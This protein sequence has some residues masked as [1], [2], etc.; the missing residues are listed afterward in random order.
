[1]KYVELKKYISLYIKSILYVWKSQKTSVSLMFIAIPLQ[2]LMPSLTIYLTNL[3]IENLTKGV[4]ERIYSI[5]CVWGLSFLLSNISSPF[6]TAIQGKLTDYLTYKLNYDIMKKSK[7]IQTIDYFEDTIFY[8][9]IQ[10]L[11]SESS[12]RPVNLLIFGTSVISNCILFISM[13]VLFY[14][15]HPVIALLMILAI[16]PQGIIA[17]KLQQ[18]S[19]ETLVSNSEDSRRLSYYSQ[20]L[21]SSETIKD[22]RLFNLYDFFLKKYTTVFE[23]IQ[24]KNQKNRIKKLI[25]SA[26]FL[27]I[28]T[29]ISVSSFIYVIFEIKNGKLGIGSI[30]VFSTSMIYSS[31]AVIRLVTDSSMLYDT[32][33]YMEKFFDFININSPTSDE[34]SIEEFPN[35]I[36][37]IEFKNVNFSY[38]NNTTFALKNISFKVKKG[39]K[40]AIV[41]ENGAGKTTLIK[42]FCHFYDLKSGDI[43]IN[44]NSINLYNPDI[45]RQN[46][47]AIFQDFS[48]FDLTLRE[49]VSISNINQI[50]NDNRIIK[51]LNKSGFKQKITLDTVLGKKFKDSRELSGGQWQKIALARA[52]FSDASVLILDEPTSAIDARTEH[53]LFKKFIELTKSKTVFYITHRLSSV[54]QADKIL[55]LR[56]GE[57]NSYGNH[58]ELIKNDSYYKELY[59]MQSSLYYDEL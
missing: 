20:A 39:E 1:M 2:S 28:T 38:E 58:E 50:Y 5:L 52:F 33:L 41:G 45:F 44:G 59:T 7:S 15:F 51:T 24:S 56:D 40:I 8:N 4:S 21:L 3:L 37:E 53:F 16:L 47:S 54:K 43:L 36:E 25:V 18:Q 31:N 35:Q 26:I 55:V 17:Y 22:I 12:W 6:L 46:I 57:I 10:I 29:I 14:G 32:L 11:S 49:N 30:M 9:D 13:L 23:I 42:L 34:T 48:K 27:V 19:F